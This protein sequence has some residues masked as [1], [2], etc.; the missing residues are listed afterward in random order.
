M[1]LRE[2]ITEITKSLDKHDLVS[3]RKNIEDNLEILSQNKHRLKGQL[4]TVFDFFTNQLNDQPLNRNDLAVI[5]TI[6]HY[7]TSFDLRGIKIVLKEHLI[8]FLKDESKVFLS[9]DAKII[10]ESMGTIPK[11]F[12]I[13]S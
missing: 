8:L 9:S 13:E 10:L 1:G 3:V 12:D 2:I 11:K 5:N 7:A 4:K 6:N